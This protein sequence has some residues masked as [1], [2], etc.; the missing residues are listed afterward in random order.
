MNE[1]DELFTAESD[2][3]TRTEGRPFDKEA[4]VERKKQERAKIYELLDRGTEIVTSNADDF[5]N[6]LDTQARFDNYSSNNAILIA[7]QH[8]ES[9]SLAEYNTWKKNDFYVKR[10]EEAIWIMERGNEYTRKDG[11]TGV[12]INVKKVFDIS[13]TRHGAPLQAKAP[14]LKTAIKALIASCPCK[15]LMDDAKTGNA[16][17]F[18]S[19]DTNAI[20]IRQGMEG[21]DIF[22]SLAQEIAVARFAEKDIDRKECAFDAYCTSYILCARNGVSTDAFNFDR[23]AER[24]E[25]VEPKAVRNQLGNIHNMS[26]EISQDMSRQFELMEKS[27]RSK[28]DGAR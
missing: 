21:E 3:E 9:T 18:Y 4:W 17:A 26:G 22:R 28:D 25:G 7:V 2:D 24:F 27:N 8:P 13:Q 23:V 16:L 12:N 19:P 10:D 6:Y 11:S 20:Y 14:E 5:R 1:Y 15:I